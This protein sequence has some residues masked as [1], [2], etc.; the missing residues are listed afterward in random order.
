MRLIIYK[1]CVVYAVMPLA[2]YYLHA[3]IHLHRLMIARSEY[4]TAAIIYSFR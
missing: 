1:F 4:I 2:L 3:H